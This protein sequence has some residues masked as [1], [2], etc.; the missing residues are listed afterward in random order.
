MAQSYT[1]IYWLARLWGGFAVAHSCFFVSIYSEHV[2]GMRLLVQTI[3]TF[4]GSCSLSS[5]CF[6]TGLWTVIKG[7]CFLISVKWYLKA[8]FILLDLDTRIACFCVLTSFICLYSHELN[9]QKGWRNSEI[10]KKLQGHGHFYHCCSHLETGV[11]L[12]ILRT[13][14][15]GHESKRSN[16]SYLLL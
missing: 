1:L 10:F 13:K 12:T 14:L 9:M 7:V 3:H 8:K 16:L 6:C 15:W 11:S 2:S 5:Y 4:Y